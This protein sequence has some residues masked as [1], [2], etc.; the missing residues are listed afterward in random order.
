[1]YSTGLLKGQPKRFVVT[2]LLAVDVPF[3]EMLRNVLQRFWLHCH[4]WRLGVL[5]SSCWAPL[6]G[7]HCLGTHLTFPGST[8]LRK[9]PHNSDY[10]VL[11]AIV[12]W[13]LHAKNHPCG[14][15]VS[16]VTIFLSSFWLWLLTRLEQHDMQ[17]NWNVPYYLAAYNYKGCLWMRLEYELVKA[18]KVC[19][20]IHRVRVRPAT[21]SVVA[22]HINK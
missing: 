10:T 22:T 6:L 1:M 15:V 9:G 5:L 21:R 8:A 4:G 3:Q 13:H 17:V 11:I 20:F 19:P 12:Y 7:H 2:P 14:E 16:A 18:K